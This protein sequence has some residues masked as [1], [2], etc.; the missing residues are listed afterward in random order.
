MSNQRK[1]TIYAAQISNAQSIK[2]AET[3]V[4]ALLK[5]VTRDTTKSGNNPGTPYYKLV[6]VK[7]GND[8]VFIKMRVKK[9]KQKSDD[10]DDNVEDMEEVDDTR[11]KGTTLNG[12]DE[13][14]CTTYDRNASTL[15]S[16]MMVKLAMTTDIYQDR[17]T[18]QA[19]SVIVERNSDILCDS[20]YK[21]NVH[22]T[23]LAVIP[24]IDNVSR[25]DFEEGI[26]EKWMNRQF[27]LPVSPE[28]PSFANVEVQITDDAT[29]C[30]F[31][32]KKE[33]PDQQYVG[34]NTQIG[35]KTV[36]MFRVV[37]TPT[38]A[39]EENG[40]K[41]TL[42]TF[43]YMSDVWDCFGCVNVE[44]WEKVAKLFI[45]GAVEWYVYG[46]S[47]LLKLESLLANKN[48]DESDDFD[49]STGF[50]TRM[51][52]NLP[53]TVKSI[54]VPLSHDFIDNHYGEDSN[55]END[56][57]YESHVLNGGWKVN[58]RR[59]KPYIVNF[60]DLSRDQ[61]T[62]FIKEIKK[63]DS[64]VQFYGI[65]EDNRAYEFVADSPEEYEGKIV[66]ANMVPDMV[67][68]VNR[69]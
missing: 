60:T 57:E 37:Y 52:V 33:D 4:D 1:R 11:P 21:E 3:L 19:G 31:T 56:H 40:A 10:D 44:T 41:K 42:I 2:P 32:R 64:K 14:L 39:E 46:Y 22:G 51:S 23:K 30:F 59:N 67:F 38:E 7:L 9:K 55:Y 17:F 34:V 24:T 29:G 5:R 15:S 25:D 61:T 54:G 16:G 13:F 27:I 20:G 62:S 66:E 28:N 18:F 26:D 68:A 65:F 63:N 58:V 8:P 36:N 47:N 45:F 6:A 50:V 12:S 35:D 69:M 53:A 43:A 49:Y 48:H